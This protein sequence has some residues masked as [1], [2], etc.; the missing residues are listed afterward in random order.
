MCLSAVLGKREFKKYYAK[1]E[2]HPRVSSIFIGWKIVRLIN[3]GGKI[4]P[5]YY[6][7]KGKS[8]PIAKWINEKNYRMKND[9]ANDEQTIFVDRSVQYKMG[10]H[11]FA[12]IEATFDY[13][14][15]NRTGVVN[16]WPASSTR[17]IKV[18]YKEVLACGVQNE[19]PVVV[20][21]NMYI[22]KQIPYTI[23]GKLSTKLLE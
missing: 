18:Y 14:R 12:T 8:F 20:V 6:P 7:Q 23:K 22:P 15:T 16:P 17:I 21:K 13:L 1:I 9:L 5:Y 2:K 19:Q 4:E 11:I 10:F 3:K